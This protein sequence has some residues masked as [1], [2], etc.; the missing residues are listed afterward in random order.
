MKHQEQLFPPSKPACVFSSWLVLLA[1]YVM[2]GVVEWCGGGV[3]GAASWSGQLFALGNQWSGVM[4]SFVCSTT[5]Q[6][7]LV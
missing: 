3:V 7:I 1:G 2:G 5:S 6:V 4:S